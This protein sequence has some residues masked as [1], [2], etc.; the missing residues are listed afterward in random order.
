EGLLIFGQD[1]EDATV[2]AVDERFVLVCNR[3]GLE[4]VSH[5]ETRDQRILVRSAVN[6]DTG[7]AGPREWR[8][9]HSWL[10]TPGWALLLPLEVGG[11]PKPNPIFGR[12]GP[13]ANPPEEA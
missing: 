13:L 3:R 10:G 7:V 9:G 6:Q 8:T 5:R 1:A 11:P 4:M 12:A 2:R